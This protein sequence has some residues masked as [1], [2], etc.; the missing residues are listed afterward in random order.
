MRARLPSVLLVGL[1]AC[2]AGAADAGAAIV[3]SAFHGGARVDAN[4]L[5][6]A[7]VAWSGPTGVRAVIGDRAGGFSPIVALS[8]TKDTF[9]S[10]QAAID[11]RGDAIVVWE[12]Y[13]RSGGGECSTCMAHLVSD[14]VWAALRRPE[15]GFGP[16]IALAGPQRD[17]GADYQLA[18]PQLALSPSGAAVVAWSDSAGAVAA[19]RSPGGGLGPPQRVQGPGFGVRSL[20]IAADGQAFAADRTGRVAVRP[21]GGAFGAPELLPGSAS[22]YGPGARLAA[23]AAGD[24]LA[25]YPGARGVLVSR[26]PAGGGWSAPLQLTAVGG[27]SERAV[28]VSDGGLGS[29]AFAQADGGRTS[30]LVGALSPDLSPDVAAVGPAGA[31]ADMAFDG[32]GLD[33]DAAGNAAV[34]FQQSSGLL[35]PGVARLAYRGAAGP[36]AA[37]AT[38]TPAGTARQPLDD[39]ADVAF[40]AGDEL[41]ATWVD[42]DADEDRVRARWYGRP[43]AGPAVTL[44]RAPSRDIALPLPGGHAA[45]L[46]T[47]P[48]RRPDRRGRILVGLRCLSLDGRPCTGALTLTAGP[49]RW[50]AGRQRFAIAPGA[51]VRLRVALTARARRVVRQRG[52]VRLT[53]TVA[54]SAPG[55]ASGATKG[56]IVVRRR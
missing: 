23:N 41:L 44:D 6:D 49:R 48:S 50:T 10:P 51:V 47:Q 55:A 45:Q 12:T 33:M 46:T 40:G 18:E 34:A 7:V 11:D 54:T 1:V 29:V 31:S 52:R 5:G 37:P 32:A 56:R 26:R 38:L 16:A 13:R 14:G 3:S 43:A 22:P 8:A 19:F 21:A 28:A 4:H 42:H 25:A 35:A 15:S 36:F 2:L 9:G 17:T 53:A 30:L 39:G 24:V 27:A 20:A